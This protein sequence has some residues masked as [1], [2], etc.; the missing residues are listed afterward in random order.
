MS[1]NTEF[2]IERPFLSIEESVNLC[3]GF[4]EDGQR[5]NNELDPL[6][7]DQELC[8][9]CRSAEDKMYEERQRDRDRREEQLGR[10]QYRF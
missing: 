8:P 5:C 6:P 1:T 3:Q 9:P 10:S 7:A 4:S 2:R